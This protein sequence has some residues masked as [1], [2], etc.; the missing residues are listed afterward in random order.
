MTAG[1]PFAEYWYRNLR[2]MVRFDRAVESAIGHG[3]GIFVEM[4]AHPALL[5]ATAQVV[6]DRP[7]VLVVRRRDAALPDE[8]SAGLAAVAAADPTQG[9][10]R[11]PAGALRDFPGAVMRAEHFWLAPERE[12]LA[13]PT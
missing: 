3:A 4:S 6:G 7:A 1:T 2:D 5:F 9:G 13:A 8:L 12:P 11:R 10:A